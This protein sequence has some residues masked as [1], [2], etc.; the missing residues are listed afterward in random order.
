MKLREVVEI[1]GKKYAV[2][3]EKYSSPYCI[4]YHVNLLTGQINGIYEDEATNED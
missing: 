3:G 2:F 4:K 1:D